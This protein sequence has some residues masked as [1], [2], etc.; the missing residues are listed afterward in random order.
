MLL[1]RTPLAGRIERAECHLLT[2]S[3]AASERRRGVRCHVLEI[4]GDAAGRGIG[5]P[6]AGHPRRKLDGP[7]HGTPPR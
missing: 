7:G 5:G 1:A 3:A 4:A 2:D 6:P